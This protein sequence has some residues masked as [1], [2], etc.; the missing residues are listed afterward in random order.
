MHMNPLHALGCNVSALALGTVK[1]GRSAG[2]HY[3]QPFA[4]PDDQAMDTLLGCAA[5]LGIN[6]LDTAPA[7]GSSEQRLGRWLRGRRKH[8]ILCS[9]T[10][11]E[12]D[13]TRSRFDFSP[14]ATR[15]SVQRSLQRLQTDY[16]DIVLLH[17]DGNDV[18]VLQQSGA[19]EA[20]RQLQREGSVRAVGISAKT[21]A[22]ALAAARS[23]D[24]A[25]LA[26]NSSDSS[27][28]PALDACAA[29]GCA[30]LVKK[31]LGSGHLCTDAEGV[32]RSL[33]FV[34][35]HPAVTS[36][37]LGTLNPAHLRQNV[38]A[39]LQMRV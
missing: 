8:W 18:P 2:L 33:A 21:L 28:G 20:L 13:G 12:F 25:M 31:A 10:G 27:M 22:G 5:E 36:I 19:M 14:E 1:L 7:Y 38:A 3:P 26:Y 39:A 35:S 30:V 11:E 23:C 32:R 15:A 16:L 29:S 17:S 24:V 6:L 4:L 37:V 9:K 34:Q